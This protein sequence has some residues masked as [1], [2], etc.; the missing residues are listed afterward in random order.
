MPEYYIQDQQL[1]NNTR[2]II[3]D[4]HGKQLFLMVGTWGRQK[5][6]LS[7]YKMN[8]Q[9]IAQIKQLSI[10]FGSRFAIYE[11]HQQ[12][13]VMRKIFNW[14]GDFYYIKQLHWAA[15]GNIYQHQYQIH[16]FNKKIMTMNTASL[17]SGDYY[18]LDIP[19][20]K[21]AAKCI[22]IAAVLDYWLYHKKPHLSS[23]LQTNEYQ[24]AILAEGYQCQ[25]KN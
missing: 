12:V 20:S 23:N 11:R 18:V 2:T 13:G 16:H 5:D 17:F 21:H 1:S 4:E 7:L 25:A 9:L 6:V 24:T 3:K 22:C 14:P 15:H 19:E 10:L 8:G